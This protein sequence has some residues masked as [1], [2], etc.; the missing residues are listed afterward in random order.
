MGVNLITTAVEM[1][2]AAPY[3]NKG[4]LGMTRL[5]A[6]RRRRKDI[7]ARDM[8]YA[9]IRASIDLQQNLQIDY[10]F[11]PDIY[12]AGNRRVTSLLVRTPLTT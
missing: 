12:K 11:T 10:F 1:T 2:A 9:G 3:Q 5:G 4:R 7:K 6:R 8:R